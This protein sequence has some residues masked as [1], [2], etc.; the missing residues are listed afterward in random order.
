MWARDVRSAIDRLSR[1]HRGQISV[2]R[3]CLSGID[4]T[5]AKAKAGEFCCRNQRAEWKLT[6]DYWVARTE[7]GGVYS[8]C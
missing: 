8:C 7:I 5:A 1:S 3:S 6:E 4:S 2:G